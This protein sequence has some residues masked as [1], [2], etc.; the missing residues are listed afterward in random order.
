MLCLAAQ[1]CPAICNPMDFVARQAPLSMGILQA[2]ILE[3]VAP[4][5]QGIVKASG[6][7]GLYREQE[8]N[9]GYWVQWARGAER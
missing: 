8:E 7:A 1:S 9:L 5:L 4:L 2:R 3:W 6:P